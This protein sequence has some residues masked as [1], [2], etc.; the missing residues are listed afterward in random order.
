MGSR[1]K[2]TGDPKILCNH[3]GCVGVNSNK[4]WTDIM[5]ALPLSV[6]CL[7]G[8]ILGGA[9]EIANS[10]GQGRATNDLGTVG[11]VVAI[12][13]LL[14]TAIATFRKTPDS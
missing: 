6:C 2:S 1:S 5:R 13:A 7:A 14:L 10:M 12:L 11:A 8:A 9:G 3:S 4:R